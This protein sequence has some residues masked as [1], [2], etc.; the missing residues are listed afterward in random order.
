M[1]HHVGT[2][3]NDSTMAKIRPAT[4][5]ESKD[6]PNCGQTI[7]RIRYTNPMTLVENEMWAQ[8]CNCAVLDEMRRVQQEN[9]A[10]NAKAREDNAIQ[11]LITNTLVSPDLKTA[12][13]SNYEPTDPNL[14]EAKALI[15][16]YV[17][18]ELEGN[19]ILH[20]TPGVGK[21]HLGF[22]AM[23]KTIRN[24][25]TALFIS[26]PLLLTKIRSTF[27]KDSEVSSDD[28]ITLCKH[29]DLLV[30][31]D[32]GIEASKEFA[33]E[34]LYIILDGR[35]GKRTMFTTNY[36]LEELYTIAKPAHASRMFGG[37]R[38]IAMNGKDYRK[39]RT[40]NW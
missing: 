28:I 26:V 27:R 19:V 16:R 30:L 29:V 7:N 34:Q 8:T 36:S 37:A 38:P 9:A 15:M 3:T 25:Q 24:G 12:T 33:M 32:V 2:Q 14:L 13:F 11:T 1:Q 31:D 6:C 10:A 21:S 22:S 35:Q 17:D 5:L 20:G 40:P 18:E 39:T 23:K 4:I